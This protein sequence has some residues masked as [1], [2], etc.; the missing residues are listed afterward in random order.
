MYRRR[1]NCRTFLILVSIVSIG[2]SMGCGQI[3]D[4][5]PNSVDAAGNPKLLK[6]IW[7]DDVNQVRRL[8]NRG[9]DPNARDA[10][11][12]PVLW[13]AIVELWWDDSGPHFADVEIVRALLDAGAD[14]EAPVDAYGTPILSVALNSRNLAAAQLLLDAG[15]DPD[16]PTYYGT[17]YLDHALGFGDIEVA[18]LLLDAGADPDSDSFGTPYLHRASGVEVVKLLLDAGADPNAYDKD[19]T[20]ALYKATW[21]GDAEVVKLLLDAGADPNT[22]D[23]AETAIRRKDAETVQVLLDAGVITAEASVVLAE[24]GWTVANGVGT[25]SR[26]VGTVGSGAGTVGSGV[27]TVGSGGS[28]VGCILMFGVGC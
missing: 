10:D 17:P 12:W 27:G 19:G 13:S 24:A 16:S 6:A 8:L 1:V 5:D 28:G 15:A 7:A 11:D 4:G 25:F 26:G 23:I 21:R 2:L 22:S 14:P 3:L 18:K 20:P 9:A